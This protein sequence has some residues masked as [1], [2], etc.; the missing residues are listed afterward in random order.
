MVDRAAVMV[1][2]SLRDA[3][4]HRRD[5]GRERVDMGVKFYGDEEG[6]SADPRGS[7]R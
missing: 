7:R 5:Q 1:C 4:R 6:T 2:Y 3:N